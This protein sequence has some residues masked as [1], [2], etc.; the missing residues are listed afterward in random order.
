MV[1][2]WGWGLGCLWLD[3]IEA[4]FVEA[5]VLVDAFVWC[6]CV[7]LRGGV[8]R[9]GVFKRCLR[10]ERGAV[11]GSSPGGLY[12]G[13]VLCAELFDKNNSGFRL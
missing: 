2:L 10:G 13:L 4:V 6:N 3:I 1:E 11:L 9:R 8:C 12:R 7:C 5:V